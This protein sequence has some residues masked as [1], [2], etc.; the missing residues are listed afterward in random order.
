MAD[1]KIPPPIR[2]GHLIHGIY[3]KDIL[4]PWDD[5]EEFVK[6]YAALKVE[7]FPNGASEDECVFDLAQAHWQKR[8]L[9]RLRTATTLRN[10]FVL[11]IKATGKNSWAGIRQGLR[12]K[13]KQESATKKEMED[14]F[15]SALSNI[16][17]LAKKISNDTSNAKVEELQPLLEEGIELMRDTVVPMLNDVR[18]MPNSERALENNHLPDDLEKVVR[19]EVLIDSRITKIMA[20]LVGIKEFKRTSAGS[21]PKQLTKS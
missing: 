18:R 9:L 4:L 12:K 10:P 1:E 11:E 17:R 15:I 2:S 20:R 14:T 5:R 16:S 3:V 21:P 13:A 6:L 19:L 8:T 7:F